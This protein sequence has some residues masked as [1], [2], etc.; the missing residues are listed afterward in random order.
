MRSSYQSGRYQDSVSASMSSL[1]FNRLSIL[2]G[3]LIW[4][5]IA[6]GQLG[7]IIPTAI[8]YWHLYCTTIERQFLWCFCNFLNCGWPDLDYTWCYGISVMISFY[9]P[10][11]FFLHKMYFL[12]FEFYVARMTPCTA[13]HVVC[14]ICL[15]PI[16]ESGAR[17]DWQRPNDLLTLCLSGCCVEKFDM[18]S[19]G[20]LRKCL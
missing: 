14:S 16:P 1:K 18:S 13:H 20:D 8:G 10:N 4:V 12:Y 5:L 7:W 15:V 9:D 2:V 3:I 17:I 6:L 11:L 19:T